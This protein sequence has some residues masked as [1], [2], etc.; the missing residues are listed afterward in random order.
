M[1]VA[2]AGTP[3][4][5]AA[6]LQALIDAGHDVR[7]V[8]TQPDRP[9]GRGLQPAASPVADLAQ[10]A[11]LSIAKPDSLSDP[12]FLAQL[13]AA[14]PEVIV[15]A[16]YGRILPASVLSLPPR[17]CLNV[18]ASLLPRWRGAAPVQRAILAGDAETGICIMEMEA[19]L[20]TGPVLL[21][22]STPIG[23]MDTGG[24]L[25]D[26]LAEIG[27][28]ALVEALQRI[29][30]LPRE[31]QGADGVCYA[32][33]LS[34]AEAWLDW[35]ADARTLARQVRAFDPFPGAETEHDGVRVKVWSA[36][37]VESS[38]AV[39]APGSVIG[40]RE[41]CPVVACG[42][43]A[44]VLLELQRPGGRRLPCADFLRGHALPQGSLFVSERKQ[45]L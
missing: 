26:R 12:T 3:S 32:V 27:G 37:A 4:F 19:G 8:F 29:D 23:P 41:G 9:R 40:T 36:H 28:A 38:G 25:T 18:H 16:A 22:R 24:S 31:P 20:D 13:R 44:L 14:K 11:G 35:R 45:P 21:R 30:R 10:R 1:R 42:D 17:G 34:R 2:F 43:G 6:S 5:A 33:K 7:L 15:V 39:E